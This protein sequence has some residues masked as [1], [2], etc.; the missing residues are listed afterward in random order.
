MRTALRHGHKAVDFLV[1][2]KRGMLTSRSSL[3]LSKTS[4]I[5]TS[6]SFGSLRKAFVRVCGLFLF[7][8]ST[9]GIAAQAV[10]FYKIFCFFY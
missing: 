8:I 4:A 7:G 3:E 9:G 5:F 10:G 6:K 2:T 1:K